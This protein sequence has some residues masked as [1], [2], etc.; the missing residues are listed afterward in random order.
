MGY[1]PTAREIA[2]ELLR[3]FCE[4]LHFH[5]ELSDYKDTEPPDGFY[6][7]EMVFDVLGLPTRDEFHRVRMP[8]PKNPDE[9]ITRDSLIQEFYRIYDDPE[10]ADDKF[11]QIYLNYLETLVQNNHEPS[12]P[13][14]PPA[15][16]N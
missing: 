15:T 11:V 1:K 10:V 16:A 12:A 2:E 8:N 9:Y 4:A 14:L 6:V 5:A 13:T 3:T 7:F